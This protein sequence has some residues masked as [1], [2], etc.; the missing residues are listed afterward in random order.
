MSQLYQVNAAQVQALNLTAG[1]YGSQVAISQL[2]GIGNS[3]QHD[4][5]EAYNFGAIEHMLS[6]LTHSTGVLRMTGLDW[7]ALAV[8]LGTDNDSSGD[9]SNRNNATAGQNLPYWSLSVAIPV[10]GGKEAH[11]HFP[12]CQLETWPEFDLG[13]ENQFMVPDLD[14]RAAR[15]QISGTAYK[16][17]YYLEKATTTALQNITAIMGLA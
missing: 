7:T 4:T 16:L 13:E 15:L 8:M 14:F 6:V 1:T 11:V 9:D 2:R 17:W 5:D 3:P 10:V 12:Y